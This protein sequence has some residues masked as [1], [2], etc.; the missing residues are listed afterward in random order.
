MKFRSVGIDEILL[1]ILEDLHQ[2]KMSKLRTKANGECS[3]IFPISREEHQG[4]LL[5]PLINVYINDVVAVLK[6]KKSP[7]SVKGISRCYY[8]HLTCL[9]YLLVVISVFL[10][11]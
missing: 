9:F 8:M 2:S 4:C 6:G 5:E 1:H 11:F 10:L 3:N 7:I